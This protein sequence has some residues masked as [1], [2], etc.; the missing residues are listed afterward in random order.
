M[1]IKD[2]VVEAG[3][4]NKLGQ[5]VGTLQNPDF[6]AGV[7]KGSDAAKKL[8]SPSQWLK[9]G[10]NKTQKTQPLQ[11]RQA[12]IAASSGRNI[13]NDDVVSLQNAYNSVRNGSI[14]PTVDPAALSV[15]LKTAYS[16]KPLNNAQKQLLMQFSKQF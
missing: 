16:Q 3:V 15:A 6:K 8:F 7:A 14:K 5:A 4:M 1:K 11:I 9:G 12:L 13:Y 10:S 2:I